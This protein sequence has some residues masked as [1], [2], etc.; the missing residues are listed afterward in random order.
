[1]NGEYLKEKDFYK[2]LNGFSNINLH[3]KLIKLIKLSIK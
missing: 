1:M 2:L 3:L